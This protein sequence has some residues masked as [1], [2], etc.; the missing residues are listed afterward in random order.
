MTQRHVLLVDIVDEPEATAA[1]EAFHA[2]GAVPTPIVASIRAAG[3]VAMDIYRTG[4][5][6]VMVME[7]DE[8]F[9]PAAKAAAD[10]ASPDVQAWETKMDAFQRRLP[11]AEPGVKWVEARRIF[12][13]AEQH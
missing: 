1:Y 12:S 9:D 8:T 6:L 5:R 2:A 7:T 3:I 13:L 4:G 11:W 10:A